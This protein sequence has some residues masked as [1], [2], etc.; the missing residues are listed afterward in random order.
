MDLSATPARQVVE[1]DIAGR[2]KIARIGL[3]LRPM[4]EAD[5]S[6]RS[7]NPVEAAGKSVDRIGE[8]LGTT[9]TYLGRIFT[10]KESG[11][12]LSGPLGIA[13]VAGGVTKQAAA[14]T[15]DPGLQAL[16]VALNLLQLAAILSIGIGFLNLLPIPILDGGHLAFYAYEAVARRPAAAKV[17]E[18]SYR[19]GLAL[20]ACFMLFAT[21]N[22][23]Q[24]L[25]LFKFLGGLA[26]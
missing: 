2:V 24:K 5:V 13:K 3:D 19:V 1:D 4:V 17:Q 20:M 21:W 22:D 7:L 6:Y 25:N 12:Q 26:S 11:D 18:V 23:L 8:V 10:G 15:N 16:T 14:D 9:V